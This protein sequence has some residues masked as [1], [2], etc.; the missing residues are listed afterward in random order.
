MI[1]SEVEAGVGERELERVG[2]WKERKEPVDWR[3]S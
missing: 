3:P 1:N 2:L